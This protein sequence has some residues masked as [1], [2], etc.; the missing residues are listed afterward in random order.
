MGIPKRGLQHYIP[1]DAVIAEAG[2]HRGFD[3][4]QFARL[5]PEGRIHAFEPVPHVY[6]HLRQNTVS[7]S[8]V[9][10]YQLALGDT[11]GAMPMWLSDPKT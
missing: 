7:H 8:N 1:T 6:E 11:D 4:V 9:K 2:A 3:T 10:A 5:W